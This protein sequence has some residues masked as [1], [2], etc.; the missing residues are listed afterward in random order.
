MSGTSTATGP[1]RGPLPTAEALASLGRTLWW[2][3]LLRGIAA[4]AFGIIA[5]AWPEISLLALVYVFGAYAIVEGVMNLAVGG[6]ERRA[7]SSRGWAIFSGILSIV[8]GIVA[9]VLPGLTSIALLFIV[10]GWAFVTGVFE[11]VHS[12]EAKAQGSKR[13]GWLLA[14]GIV[15]VIFAL[16]IVIFPGTGL[17]SLVWLVGFYAIVFGASLVGA[18]FMVR[19]AVRAGSGA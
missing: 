5:L 3:V 16:V 15:S 6:T 1:G 19:A 14:S 18:A 13:W 9:F 7:G 17:V 12:F 2:V 11:V 10:A 4:V 8:A